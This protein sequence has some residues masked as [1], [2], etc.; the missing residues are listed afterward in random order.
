MSKI[1]MNPFILSR[2]AFFSQ[3]EGKTNNMNTNS[4]EQ[5]TKDTLKLPR[6]KTKKQQRRMPKI[7]ITVTCAEHQLA[8]QPK[9]KLN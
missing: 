9:L 8:K 1:E 3:Y 2:H 5:R 6:K 7:L 4:I